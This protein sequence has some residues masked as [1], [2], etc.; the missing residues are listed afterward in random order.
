MNNIGT[1]RSSIIARHSDHSRLRAQQR[2][3]TNEALQMVLFAA[4]RNVHLGSGVRAV[5]LSKRKA[6]KLRDSGLP[7][8]VISR[9]THV[10]LLVAE[11][12][13]VIITT[14]VGSQAAGRKSGRQRVCRGGKR[15]FE[16]R[17][18]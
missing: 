5:S 9:A 10:T 7:D 18:H 4:D 8:A 11:D 1:E 6:Q 13:G 16:Q 12:T 14:L 15:H 2:G 17:R 3:V